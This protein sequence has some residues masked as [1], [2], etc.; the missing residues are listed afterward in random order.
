MWPHWQPHLAA[1]IYKNYR[2]N[3]K[4]MGIV[5]FGFTSFT[6]LFMFFHLENKLR[7][8]SKKMWLPLLATLAV[9]YIG[10]PQ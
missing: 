10:Q 1:T 4:K 3:M 6:N 5:H 8:W 2:R 7:G 9:T